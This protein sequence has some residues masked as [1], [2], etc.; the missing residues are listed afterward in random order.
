M[1]CN[2]EQHVR[3]L[4][5]FSGSTNLALSIVDAYCLSIDLKEEYI[6]TVVFIKY[7]KNHKI[8]LKIIYGFLINVKLSTFYFK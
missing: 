5:E 7:F 1:S 6:F 3:K 8:F 4:R 2:K